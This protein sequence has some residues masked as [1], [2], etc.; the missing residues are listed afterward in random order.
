VTEAAIEPLR[1][2]FEVDRPAGHA[3]DV[4]TRDIGRWWPAD[5]TATAEPDLDVVLE[6]WVG[7]RFFER[8]ADGSELDWGEVLVWDPPERFVYTWHLKRDRRDATEVEIRFVPTS[9][10]STR[11]EIEHRGWERL[12]SDGP[13]WRD[14]NR[15]GWDSLLPHYLAALVA[16]G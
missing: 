5:H 11:V 10:A 6:P 2:T 1:L 9:S 15:G 16:G 3:F 14:R 4:W 7:G 12:G 13:T 8:T